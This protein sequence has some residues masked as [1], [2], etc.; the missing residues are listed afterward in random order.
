MCHLAILSGAKIWIM[1]LT[2]LPHLGPRI[3]RRG[4]IFILPTQ[5]FTASSLPTF[6][7]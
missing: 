5:A 7:F 1:E 2:A 4:A 3:R 6:S